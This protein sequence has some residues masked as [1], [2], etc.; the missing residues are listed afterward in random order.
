MAVQEYQYPS[1]FAAP[2]PDAVLDADIIGVPAD[3]DVTTLPPGIDVAGGWFVVGIDT[4][5]VR[6]WIL[7]SA[8]SGSGP[9]TFT[10]GPSGRGFGGS[11][12]ADHGAGDPIYLELTKENFIGLLQ[13]QIHTPNTL[14]LPEKPEPSTPDTGLQELY[15]DDTTHTLTRK[16]DAGTVTDIEAGGG[17][18]SGDLVLLHSVTP[19]GV[20]NTTLTPS[21]SYRHLLIKGVAQTTDAASQ[22]MALQFNGDAGSNYYFFRTFI[23]SAGFSSGN[24]GAGVTSGECGAA[25]K[26]SLTGYFSHVDIHINDYAGGNKK[27]WN[28][29]ASLVNA[30]TATNMFRHGAD[31]WWDSTAAITSIKL[32]LGAGNFQAGTRFDLY[33]YN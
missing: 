28:S 1:S 8:V 24:D 33:G 18:G 3:F 7:V 31:G 2:G 22:V 14:L 10:I 4:A 16:D 23:N 27:Q 26:S 19:S 17:G 12:P 11:A 29:T 13:G 32:I 21:G 9:Y 30:L 5:G 25:N 20:T 15:I 6:E